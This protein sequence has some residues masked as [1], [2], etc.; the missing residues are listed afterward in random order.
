MLKPLTFLLLLLAPSL[1]F[2]DTKV[3]TLKDGSQIKGE[4]TGISGDIYTIKTPLM[5]DVKVDSTQVDSISAEG[6]V[7]PGM[8]SSAD[9]SQKMQTMQTELMSNPDV[10][11]DIQQ[12][13]QDP[14]IVQIMSDPAFV[15]AIT[16][17]DLNAIQSNPHTQELMNNPKMRDLIEKIRGSSASQ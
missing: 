13:M 15:Q 3:I 12:M 6:A 5:G 1:V 14:E 7:Q 17:K 16:S 10:M 9:L 8:P 11:S 4:L 2:A